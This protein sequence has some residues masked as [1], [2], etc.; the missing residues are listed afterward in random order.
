MTRATTHFIDHIHPI[1]KGMYRDSLEKVSRLIVKQVAKTL[2]ATNFAI[3]L[4]ASKEF[5]MNY[6]FHNGNGEK[7]MLNG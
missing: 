6:L 7:K 3:A 4:F 5:F 1:A 2:S